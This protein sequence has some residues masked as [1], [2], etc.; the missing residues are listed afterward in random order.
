MHTKSRPGIHLGDATADI[1][2][3]VG[4]IV[5]KKI[6]T[7]DIESNRTDRANGHLTII[8][9]HHIGNVDRCT[10]GRQVGSGA[11]EK[12]LIFL[13]LLGNRRCQFKPII[14]LRR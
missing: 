5:G 1:F 4:N 7:T 8:R 13:P 3:G 9:M 12:S 11:K 14:C 2:I 10:A 6:D